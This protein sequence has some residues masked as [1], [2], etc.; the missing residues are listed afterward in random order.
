MFDRQICH[1][2]LPFENQK[3]LLVLSL[4]RL[5]QMRGSGLPDGTYSSKW[6]SLGPNVIF[7]LDLQLLASLGIGHIWLCH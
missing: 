2:G 7:F 6:E 3:A 4:S 1:G 5:W